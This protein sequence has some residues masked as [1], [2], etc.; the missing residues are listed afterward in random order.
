M[1]SEC[2]GDKKKKKK[3]AKV[4]VC[5]YIDI[6]KNLMLFQQMNSMATRHSLSRSI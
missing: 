3:K 6:N 4:F 2:L 1:S 5:Y